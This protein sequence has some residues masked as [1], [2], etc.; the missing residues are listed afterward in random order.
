MLF[1]EP[2]RTRRLRNSLRDRRPDG[3]LGS[4]WTSPGL[5][6]S[7][8]SFT[9]ERGSAWPVLPEQLP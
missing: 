3:A 5:P 8:V 4:E 7:A 6:G 1:I 2:H 9:L